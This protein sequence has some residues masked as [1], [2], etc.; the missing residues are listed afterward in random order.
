MLARRA[1]LVVSG[2]KTLKWQASFVWCAPAVSY[3]EPVITA[4][5]RRE[6]K[7]L[8]M[9]ASNLAQ[10]LWALLLV[11]EHTGSSMSSALA[12]GPYRTLYP[13]S[14][15]TGRKGDLLVLPR[16]DPELSKEQGLESGAEA[17]KNCVVYT[18]H[19]EYSL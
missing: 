12:P 16:G 6:T 2:S 7:F 8:T 13:L 4:S 5:K 19:T 14:E 11:N 15:D 17:H 1:F 9:Q 10:K 3:I 18:V